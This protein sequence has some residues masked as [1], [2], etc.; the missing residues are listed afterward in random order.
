M[1]RLKFILGLVAGTAVLSMMGCDL[2]IR[3]GNEYAA[4][5]GRAEETKDENNLTYYKFTVDSSSA[6]YTTVDN[7]GAIDANKAQSTTTYDA[8]AAVQWEN[9]LF[10]KE[11]VDLTKGITLV[12]DIY[13]TSGATYDAVLTFY[14]KGDDQYR[15]LGIFEAGNT[16]FKYTGDDGNDYESLWAENAEA[17]GFSYEDAVISTG[18][19]HKIALVLGEDNSVAMYMDAV[20]VSD[21]LTGGSYTL[22]N[23]VDF[24][25]NTADTLAVGVGFSKWGASFVDAKTYIGND[26]RLYTKELSQNELAKVFGSK[27]T[28]YADADDV[29][30]QFKELEGN[31][32]GLKKFILAIIK[33]DGVNSFIEAGITV[34]DLLEAG[35]FKTEEL[36]GVF[37]D[38]D[39]TDGASSYNMT[40]DSIT[41]DNV[42]KGSD[43]HITTDVYITDYE[44]AAKHTDAGI[45]KCAQLMG[46]GT[47]EYTISDITVTGAIPEFWGIYNFGFTNRLTGKKYAVRSD[48]WN[49]NLTAFASEIT[50]KWPNVNGVTFE[51][52]D[53]VNCLSKDPYSC[54]KLILSLE[55]SKSTN[56][57]TLTVYTVNGNNPKEE[58]AKATWDLDK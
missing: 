6:Y 13:N 54:D 11:D 31:L 57:A 45:Q 43:I 1:K 12:T 51:G 41:I 5:S 3:D 40:V 24:L 20:K 48:G 22:N 16:R 56:K 34:Q 17:K 36:F 39:S 33:K 2:S 38:L 35:A 46:Y 26:T 8:N 50:G 7:V 42:S 28:N 10:G 52:E 55:L 27:I 37:L 30:E 9:P 58:L 32:S 15:A 18:A 14:Q 44:A 53:G 25:T 21:G 23:V 4:E 49:N 19:W 47:I 29:A